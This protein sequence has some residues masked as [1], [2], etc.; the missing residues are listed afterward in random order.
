MG[1]G[2]PDLLSGQST[3]AVENGS[4]GSPPVAMTSD[5]AHILQAGHGEISLTAAG[6]GED[7]RAH[8]DA[9]ED[10]RNKN[11][12]PGVNHRIRLLDRARRGMVEAAAKVATACTEARAAIDPGTGQ[13]KTLKG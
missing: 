9:A 8:G 12:D 5:E 10:E 7:D 6:L 1:K 11:D 2:I 13:R 3:G 4:A